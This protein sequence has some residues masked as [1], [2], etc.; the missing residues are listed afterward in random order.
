MNAPERFTTWRWE[1]EDEGQKLQYVPDTKTANSGMF[2]LGKE[3]HT[4]GNLMRL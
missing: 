2:I 1:D 4:I 3:D